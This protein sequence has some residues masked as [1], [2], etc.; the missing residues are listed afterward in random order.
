MTQDWTNRV[1]LDKGVSIE[2]SGRWE[3]NNARLGKHVAVFSE[4]QSI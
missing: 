1:V 3:V 4:G 2:G